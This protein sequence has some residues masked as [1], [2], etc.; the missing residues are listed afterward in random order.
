VAVRWLEPPD[1]ASLARA[2]LQAMLGAALEIAECRRVL[3]KGGLNLVG[4]VLRG[5][6]RFVEYEHYPENDV[7]DAETRSQYYYHAHRGIAGEH[8]HF[9]TFVR[10]PVAGVPEG[11]A[12]PLVAISMD[13]YGWPIGLFATNHWVT[14]GL[15]LPA[16]ETVPLLARFR[17]DHAYPSWPLNRWI[18]A[19]F[20]LYRPHMARLLAHRDAVLE[21]RASANPG[22][23]VRED[24][25]LDVTGYLPV[26]VDDTLGELRRLLAAPE[27]IS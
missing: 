21:Q 24:R 15:W 27:A 19:M 22:I 10:L 11:E 9:H 13:P 20:V 8:G 1:L 7:Y 26:S 4:E 25:D 14:G 6:G 18:S 5:A 17:V 12:V 16:S 3:A 2:E 23:E